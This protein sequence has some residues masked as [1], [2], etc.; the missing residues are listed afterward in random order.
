MGKSET[1]KYIIEDSAI[2]EMLGRQNFSNKVS[3]ILELVKNSYD[4][5]AKKLVIKISDNTI[6]LIDDGIGMNED[7]IRNRWMHVGYSEKSSLY[8]VEVNNERR[9]VSGSKGVGR[10]AL[11]RLG[12]EVE[13]V[14]KKEGFPAVLWKTNWDTCNLS[15]IDKE[16]NGTSIIIKSLRD[17]W[18]KSEVKKL[19]AYLNKVFSDDKM[20]ISVCFYDF[21]LSVIQYFKNNIT[22]NNYQSKI[23]F[24]F[25]SSKNNL[26]VEVLSDEFTDEAK[27]YY[28]EDNLNYYN[29]AINIYDELKNKYPSLSVE[30][31][32][33]LITDLGSFEGVFYFSN[34]STKNDAEKFCYKTNKNHILESGIVLYRN[35]FSI[36]SYEGK[37]DWLD[38]GKRSRKS[39]AAATHKTGA[40]RVR[41]NQLS[42]YVIIDKLE[43]ANIKELSNRQGLEEDDYYSLFI[44][45]IHVALNC[46]ERYRQNI[47][48]NIDNKNHVKKEPVQNNLLSIIESDPYSIKK[49]TEE[50][51]SRVSEG[52]KEIK[53]TNK[54]LVEESIKNEDD[55]KYDVRILNVLSTLGLKASSIAHELQNDRNLISSNFDNIINRMKEL[56][57]W[58][59]VDSQENK[60]RAYQ[61]IPSMFEKYK[62]VNSKMLNFMDV[63]LTNIEKSHFEDHKYVLSEIIDEICEEWK[64]QYSSL[65]FSINNNQLIEMLI[66]YDFINVIFDNLILNS[67]QQNDKLNTLKIQIDIGVENNDIIIEY[68]DNG[69]G[70]V[71]KYLDRPMRILDVHETSR[72]NG[73]GLGM[74]IVNKSLETLG[75][76]VIEIKGDNGFYIRFSL[77]GRLNV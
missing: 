27:E 20:K 29:C 9:I 42:G 30:D 25:D 11:S 10:F 50:Q 13:I 48:R 59:I 62:K 35:S 14:S 74:W 18:N 53:S 4:A 56:G 15:L 63:M 47:I 57:V 75:G 45:I 72:E 58:E 68:K 19:V 12:N 17:K 43:N 3:A 34:N 24:H 37:K 16:K 39:P 46:F 41:E 22:Y 54:K 32:T 65:E 44:D 33:K 73:H 70:L 76:R 60:K 55:Y 36:S 5:F 52:I 28:K 1:L 40:W 66:S 2:A 38:L 7:D 77:G 21:E 67:V 49:M 23:Q 8:E 69:R 64:K 6:E 61:N 26:N 51:L 71:K 31:F